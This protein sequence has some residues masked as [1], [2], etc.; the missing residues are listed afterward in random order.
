MDPPERVSPGVPRARLLPPSAAQLP[1]AQ[2]CG[3]CLTQKRGHKPHLGDQ[4]SKAQRGLFLG[5]D[6]VRMLPQEGKCHEQSGCLPAQGC[7][8]H[9]G[10]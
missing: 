2:G 6:M 5:W 4:L 1:V 8:F 3:A 9:P 7:L 10:S